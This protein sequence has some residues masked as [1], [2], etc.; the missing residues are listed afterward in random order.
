[1]KHYIIISVL[2]GLVAFAGCSKS[3]DQD[4]TS[5]NSQRPKSDDNEKTLVSE[6]PKGPWGADGQSVLLKAKWIRG[7]SYVFRQTTDMEMELPIAGPEGSKTKMSMDFNVDVSDNKGSEKQQMIVQ[8]TKV[9]MEMSMAGQNMIYDSE[10]PEKQSALLKTAFGDFAN[11]KFEAE[12][13]K[14]GNFLN[15]AEN[16]NKQGGAPAVAGIGGLGN[17]EIANML[18]QLGDF[19]FPDKTVDPATKWQHGQELSMQQIGKMKMTIDYTYKGPKDHGGKKLAE[20]VFQGIADTDGEGGLVSFKDSKM[21]GTMLF[22]PELGTV[23]QSNSSVDMTM[24]VGGELGAEM[25]TKTNSSY[26]L[27]S[28][29]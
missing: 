26:S 9:K 11:Q 8:F 4:Q 1:M 12:L 22:D 13:D 15:V 18:K 5:G 3:N 16:A 29:D 28:I 24:S 2:F 6:N 21:S 19:G 25:D 20:I 17:E 23:V 7:K 27:I 14:N 10:D